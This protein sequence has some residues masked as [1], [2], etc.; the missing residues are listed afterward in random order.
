[1]NCQSSFNIFLAHQMSNSSSP[2]TAKKPF[3]YSVQKM[4]WAGLFSA[5]KLVCENTILSTAKGGQRILTWGE[6]SRASQPQHGCAARRPGHRLQ[7]GRTEDRAGMLLTN[8]NKRMQRA[9]CSTDNPAAGHRREKGRKCAPGS[10]QKKTKPQGTRSGGSR[11]LSK[12][13][14]ANCD[15][16]TA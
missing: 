11:L 10:Q 6:W 1:M 15:A 13:S 14:K 5:N 8:L 12:Q 16:F 3:M 9:A 4:I 7:A 2:L